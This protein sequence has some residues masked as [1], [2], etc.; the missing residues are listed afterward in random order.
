MKLC[1]KL[2]RTVSLLLALALVPALARAEPD[3]LLTL[4][5][6]VVEDIGALPV[7]NQSGLKSGDV[8]VSWRQPASHSAYPSPGQGNL[9]TILDWHWLILEKAPTGPILL[10]RSSQG[11][12]QEILIPMGLADLKMRP[13]FKPAALSLYDNGK[14]QIDHGDIDEGLCWWKQLA[15]LAQESADP[16]LAVWLRLRMAAILSERNQWNEA[17]AIL[18]LA[19][20]EEISPTVRAA[21]LEDLGTGFRRWGKTDLAREAYNAALTIQTG[22]S[23][24]TLALARVSF[25]LALIESEQPNPAG[26]LL[27]AAVEQI[28][29]LAPRSTVLASA[30]NNRGIFRLN[31]G[32]IG[33]AQN[34]Y[35]LAFLLYT[36]I[37]PGSLNVARV[38]NNLGRV[39]TASGQLLQAREW[40]REA[41][42]LRNLLAPCSLEVAQSLQNLAFIEAK[43]GDP[44]KGKSLLEQALA[45]LHDFPGQPR[46]AGEV[47]ES[48]GFLAARTGN[49][50]EA[51]TSYRRALALFQQAKPR[52]LDVAR[53][54]AN[55]STMLSDQG[56]LQG[57]EDL[58]IDSLK[59]GEEIAPEGLGITQTLTN[60]GLLKIR[61]GKLDEA[62]DF[63][64]RSLR[65]IERIAPGTF[66]E[67]AILNNLGM[68]AFE[69]GDTDDASY[70]DKRSLEVARRLPRPNI[71]EAHS[72]NNLGNVAIT[73]GNYAEA[74]DDFKESLAIKSKL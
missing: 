4:P 27:D 33:N 39:A 70:F 24:N 42:R 49:L 54:Q 13:N 36:E 40:H 8:L 28:Q 65:I 66:G 71:D 64:K 56:D 45:I 63:L 43:M 29:L 61:G 59:L 34:D 15:R 41:L 11:W 6:V 9:E 18:E 67:A 26:E 19:L 52:S 16:L 48:L 2:P 57:A 38:M 73:Q 55:L 62:E 20:R 22:A 10:V 3:N 35:E 17:V 44:E 68:L 25:F 72:L 30:L 47:I 37:E 53:A 21:V 74:E 31:R 32:E 46:Q 1:G 5:G 14:V 7:L 23:N 58:L 12:P 60:I 69:R 50:R 51:E